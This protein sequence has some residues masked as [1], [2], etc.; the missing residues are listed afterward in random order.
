M[1]GGGGALPSREG[2]AV[3]SSNPGARRLLPPTLLPNEAAPRE[4]PSP[5]SRER[6]S[7]LGKG[8]NVSGRGA[9]FPTGAVVGFSGLGGRGR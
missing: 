9:V 2:G 1:T 5:L 3:S 4:R 6:C 8:G 7:R